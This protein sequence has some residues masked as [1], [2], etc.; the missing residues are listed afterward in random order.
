MTWLTQFYVARTGL[1][2]AV[3]AFLGGAGGSLLAGEAIVFGSQKTKVEPGKDKTP[4]Q[5]LF[6]LD[7]LTSPAPLEMDGITAPML[8]QSNSNFRKDKRQQNADDE[9]KN[10]LLLE[11]GELQASDDEKGFMGVRD[12]DLSE[13]EKGKD[14]HDYTFSDSKS[15]R[16]PNQ[17][18]APNQSQSRAP[19]QRRKPDPNQ[20]AQ[21]RE[22]EDASDSKRS[23]SSAI[24]FGS[25]NAPAGARDGDELNLKKLLGSGAGDRGSSKSEFSL[26]DLVSS[27]DSDWNRE[28]RARNTESFKQLL[29]GSAAPGGLGDSFGPRPDFMRQPVNPA[30]PYSLGDPSR[31]SPAMESFT[32][33]QGVGQPNAPLNYLSS[34]DGPARGGLGAPP[35]AP[36]GWRATPVEWPKSRF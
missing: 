28:Q 22:E 16:L 35:A 10:W 5:N 23:R 17:L 9:K 14:G 4:A 1:L 18:R 25:R 19:G 33:R 15:S 24:V 21:Q 11:K 20:A 31:K 8:P 34:P 30:M 36:G 13:I 6:R 26:R 29:G 3:T 2:L 32:T 12:N 27:G 7:K